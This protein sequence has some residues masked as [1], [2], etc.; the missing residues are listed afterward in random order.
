MDIN[1]FG[2]LKLHHTGSRPAQV[3][4]RPDITH[5]VVRLVTVLDAWLASH[6]WLDYLKS[7][8]MENHTTWKTTILRKEKFTEKAEEYI[9]G[10]VTSLRKY[11]V[12]KYRLQFGSGLTNSRQGKPDSFA[13]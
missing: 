9:K 3:A 6:Y 7:T 5:L 1:I 11:F 12:K 13:E 2:P 4:V 8:I 10:K